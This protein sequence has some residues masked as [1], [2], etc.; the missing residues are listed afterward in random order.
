MTI[1]YSILY[2]FLLKICIEISVGTIFHSNHPYLFRVFITD[3]TSFYEPNDST[4]A[5]QLFQNFILVKS[6]VGSFQK[7]FY[8]W[9]FVLKKQKRNTTPVSCCK[10]WFTHKIRYFLVNKQVPYFMGKP[11]FATADRRHITF[12]L[13]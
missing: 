13:L 4:F 10:N 3:Q 12:R 8:F 9:K 5:I 7:L 6:L 11:I 2:I 1:W